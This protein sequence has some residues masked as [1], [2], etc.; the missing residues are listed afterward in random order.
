MK[1]TN[2]LLCFSRRP[3]F[4][5]LLRGLYPLVFMSDDLSRISVIVNE[6]KETV[7]F[8]CVMRIG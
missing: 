1:V 2:D 4:V 5:S 7:L 6:D 3:P 8:C